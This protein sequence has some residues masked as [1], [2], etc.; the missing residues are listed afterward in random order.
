MTTHIATL[1]RAR[2]QAL[3]A[4]SGSTHPHAALRVGPTVTRWEAT[5]RCRLLLLPVARPAGLGLGVYMLEAPALR[6]C[7]S[8]TKQIRI[9]SDDV[10]MVRPAVGDEWPDVDMAIGG[11]FRSDSHDTFAVDPRLLASTMTTLAKLGAVAVKV[12]H[13]GSHLDPLELTS[14][15]R[16][17]VDFT[18]YMMPVRLD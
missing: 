7:A 15:D 14:R 12:R 16:P 13:L 11:P 4:F 8:L 3:R 2:A 5:D 18:A 1:D 9:D 10:V 17:V 6:R